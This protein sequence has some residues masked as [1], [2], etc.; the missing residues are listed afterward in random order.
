MPL[1]QDSIQ[2]EGLSDTKSFRTQACV[3]PTAASTLILTTSSQMAQIL[4]GTTNGQVIQLPNA[5]TLS[6]G[7]KFEVYNVSTVSIAIND[8][9]GN[10]QAT[11]QGSN[12][13]YIELQ[14]NTTSD[15]VWI[16]SVLGMDNTSGA[17]VIYFSGKGIKNAYIGGPV[18]SITSSDVACP[19]FPRPI[20]VIGW[21]VDNGLLNTPPGVYSNFNIRLEENANLGVGLVTLDCNRGRYN[22]GWNPSGYCTYSTGQGMSVYIG[23]GSDNRNVS[24]TLSIWFVW[25][26]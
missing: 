18:S 5:T 21:A 16:I 6:I 12:T 17:M 23:A 4:T 14:D 11:I 1:L 7:H 9:R 2:V 25:N 24:P 15:G 22:G 19:R 10:L 13:A 8:G 26:D 20:K 3:Q